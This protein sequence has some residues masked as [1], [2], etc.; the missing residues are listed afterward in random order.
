M[1]AILFYIFYGINWVMTFL[2][3]RVLYLFSYLFFILMY[4]FPGYRR[5]VVWGNLK[6]SF[7][8]KPD[9]ELKVLMRK[10]YIHLSDI[11]IEVLKLQNMKER[12]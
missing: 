7:P 2:P 4:Y 6:N 10:F 5:E 3:L 11:F 9:H 8:D 12:F 1:K